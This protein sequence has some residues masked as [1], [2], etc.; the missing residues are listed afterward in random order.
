M[1]IQ[2]KKFRIYKEQINLKFSTQKKMNKGFKQVIPRKGNLQ[3]NTHMKSDSIVP[4]T[5]ETQRKVTT[6]EWQ[7]FTR[8]KKQVLERTWINRLST[9]GRSFKW[10]NHTTQAATCTK[11][12]NVY[13][14]RP[15]ILFLVYILERPSYMCIEV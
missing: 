11:F 2:R 4:V 9:V 1:Y 8:P 3:A 10:Y 7:K 5:K 12:E 6:S 14:L 15:V 13:F